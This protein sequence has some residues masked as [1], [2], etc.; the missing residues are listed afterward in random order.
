MKVN[1]KTYFEMPF[2]QFVESYPSSFALLKEYLPDY[3]EFLTD[4]LYVIRVSPDGKIEVGY[5][6]DSWYIH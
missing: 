3:E 5:P 1:R 4:P 6:E 2:S